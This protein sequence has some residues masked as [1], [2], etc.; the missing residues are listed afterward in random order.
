MSAL[1][2]LVTTARDRAGN[3]PIF[4]WAGEARRRAA[5]GDDIVNCTIGALTN[6]DGSL[7]VLP[8]VLETLRRFQ[9]AETAGYAPISGLP[10]YREAVVHD[11]FGS[12]PLAAQA[13]AVTTPGGTG[14]VYNAVAN[15]LEEGQKML[16]SEFFWGPYREI[17][18]HGGK[19]LDPFP[20]FAADG[21]FN[22]DGMA[23]GLE[24][25]LDT[26]GRALLVL[27]FP[28]HNPT[29]YT[30]SPEEWVRVTDVVREAGARGPVTVLLDVAYFEFG[31][32]SARTWLD[33]VPGL[34]ENATVLIGWTASKAMAQY[35]ARL[36]AVVGLH[37]DPAELQQIENA[38]G[39]TCRATWS[40]SNHV[41]Q[42]AVAELLTDPE[43]AGRVQAERDAMCSM[44]RG[45]IDHFN[46]LAARA[47]LPIPR[48]DA[49]FF[50]AVFTRDQDATAAAMRERGVYTVPIPG[51]VRV[52][53]CS[54]PA[55][56]I[57]RVV[58]ALE[59]GVAAAE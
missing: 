38:L 30:L 46:E 49:G 41:G 18:G 42:R 57:P 11:L 24:R 56:A 20:M 4:I 5:A 6:E 29:G 58:E 45:R 39:Y 33:A 53:I 44:L 47:S 17:T 9:T 50:V 12:G 26:Q 40:N 2:S 35:G 16:V 51:A 19:G 8:T 22:I 59:V 43:L 21:S 13:V 3:D 52:A 34:M 28:C 27:N 1:C 55:A 31:E 54:T 48:Y 25:H 32:A 14:A 7:A 10:A 23:A 15:F 37:Q 36:G